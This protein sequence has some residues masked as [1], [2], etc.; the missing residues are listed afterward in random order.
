MKTVR[1]VV[2]ATVAAAF[3]TAL[4]AQAISAPQRYRPKAAGPT[5]NLGMAQKYEQEATTWRIEAANHRQMAVD[6]KRFSKSPLNPA[7]PEMQRHCTSMVEAAVA[8]AAE[9]DRLA[10]EYRLLAKAD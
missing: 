1:F 10:A 8:R 9:A 4:P 7:I 2:A 3:I 6:Y 5:T